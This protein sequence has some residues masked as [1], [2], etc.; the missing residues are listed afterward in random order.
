MDVTYDTLKARLLE[1][2]ILSVQEKMDVLFKM[3]PLGGRKPSQLLA[4][5]TARRP[6]SRRPCSSTYSCSS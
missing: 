4:S 6:W 3:E 5:L 2:P 1:T